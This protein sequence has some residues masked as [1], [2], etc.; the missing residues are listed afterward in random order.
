MVQI[1]GLVLIS[2]PLDLISAA[3][4]LRAWL[5]GNEAQEDLLHRPQRSESRSLRVY[6]PNAA[7]ATKFYKN[8]TSRLI[9]GSVHDATTIT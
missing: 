5:G 7:D 4:N 9:S 2:A 6:G 1:F 8:W 3:V